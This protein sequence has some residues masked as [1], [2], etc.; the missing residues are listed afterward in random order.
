M[1][2]CGNKHEEICYEG[3]ECPMCTLIE[4]K[5]ADILYLQR[6]VAELKIELEQAS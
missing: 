3:R 1:N 6:Q 4:T 2:L 5:D